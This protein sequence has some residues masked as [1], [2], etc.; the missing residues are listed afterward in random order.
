M[1]LFC[2]YC[3]SAQENKSTIPLINEESQKKLENEKEEKLNNNNSI[4]SISS[5]LNQKKLFYKNSN[6]FSPEKDSKGNSIFEMKMPYI[7]LFCGGEFC[8]Y[9]NPSNDIKSDMKG[10]IANLYFDCVYASQRPCTKLIEKYKLIEIFKQNNIKLIV[11]CQIN[12]EHPYCGPNN[13]LEKDC[14]FSYS[15]SVFTSEGIEVLNKGFEDLQI[16]YTFDFML[17]IVKKMAY[18]VKYKKGRVLVHCHAGNGRTGIVIV[19]FLIYYFNLSYMQAIDK[20]REVRK[21]AVEKPIQELFCN[22]FEAF[23]NDAKNLFPNKI[24]KIGDFIHNQNKMNFNFNEDK[25]GI[26]SIIVSYYF[27]NSNNNIVNKKDI[28][29]KIIDI[30]FIPKII[31][32]CI[33]KIVEQKI[34]NKINL[35][36]LYDI[37]NGKKEINE[38]TIQ[39]EQ[40]ISQ[41]KNYNWEIFDKETDL[42][43]ISEILFIWLNNKVI[44][45]ISPQKI[46]K[47]IISIINIYLGE[48]IENLKLNDNKENDNNNKILNINIHKLFERYIN[49]MQ[50]K[51]EIKKILV[52]IKVNLTKVEYELIKYL[53]LFLQ[54]IYP[55]NNH[56]DANIQNEVKTFDNEL[57]NEYKRFLYKLN[58][59][60]LGYNLDKI[61]LNPDYFSP[62]IELLH[63]KMLIFIFELFI[64]YY[65]DNLDSELNYKEDIYFLYKNRTNFKSINNFL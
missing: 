20:L 5:I 27:K 65:S 4:K 7:C 41:L 29:D 15:P 52:L 33:E 57:I 37:L 30:N 22:K 31:F 21:K 35:K 63:A 8:K 42:N 9:E 46:S 50:Y 47:T 60:L 40:I 19:C 2:N 45:C 56:N 51:D 59:F 32:E 64:F 13:G 38:E 14:G 44:F 53:S 18:V 58:L 36:D 23:I 49:N 3:T 34:I 43:I 55:T 12:G 26:P 16:P 28:Y 25:I 6:D 10:L 54:I 11:N 62:S 1:A 48:K 61:N 24:K 17:D 39:I